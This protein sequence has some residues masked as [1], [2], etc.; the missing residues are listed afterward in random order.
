M[1]PQPL[2][3]DPEVTDA[4]AREHGLTDD[5]YARVQEVLGRVP[6]YTELGVYSVMWSEHCSY[7]NS[8]ALLKTLP[9]D[10][11]RLL[12]AAGDENAGLVDI[13]GGLACA[14][15]IESHNHPSAV[16]PYQ[17]AATGVG[18]IQRDIFTMGARP[19]ASLN[20]LRFGSLDS[21]RVRFLF[22][23]V[24]RG[25]GGYGNSF[26]VPTVGGEV[27]F[28]AS[29]EGNPLVNAMSVG[30]VKAGET[31]SATAEGVGNPVYIVG[32]ATGRDGIHGA[33]FASEEISEDSDA[34]RPNVQV[35]DPF[36]EKLLLE[37]SLEA[38][39]T[40]AVVGMQDMGAA[41]ITCSSSEMSE[42]GGVG[43]DLQLDRTPQREAG[44]TPYELLLSESQERMLV[45]V[46]R[47]REAE[48]EA[49]FDKWDLHAVQIGEVTDTE[50][51]RV[52]WHGD[53]VVDVPA[54]SLV[55]GGGAP[56]Y[57]RETQRPGYLDATRAWDA[58]DLA[59]LLPTSAETGAG[60]AGG[61]LVALMGAP[62]VAS[63]R[64]VFQQY[65]HEV[66]TNTVAGPGP[67][68]A[69]VVRLKGTTPPAA[70]GPGGAGSP[71]GAERGLAMTT[72]CNGRYVYLNPRRG[73]RIAVAEAARNVVCAGGEPLAV[74]NCLN[75]G[76]PYKPE[77]YW[78]FTEAVGGLGDACRALGTPVTGGNVSFYNE[79][80]DERGG[81]RA[82][83]PTPTIGMVGL[84]DDVAAHTTT[85][86]WA[87]PGD[88]LL[89]VSP[90]AWW[91]TGGVEASEYLAHVHGTTAGDA[92]HLDLD[93]EKAVQAAVLAAIRAGLV[94]SAH[95][96][97]D[98]GLA[99]SLAESA[100][101]S[102]LGAEVAL[103]ALDARLDAVLFGEAQSRV[104]LSVAPD[105]AQ[106]VRA[107]CAEHGAQATPIGT[108][109]DGPLQ[110]TVGA[111]PALSVPVADLA[112]PYET[113]I[114]DAM[115]A[116]EARGGPAV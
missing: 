71:G 88:R 77:V 63:K 109:T 44:M 38:I 14:F 78:Q 98:G 34:K 36:T 83:F 60:T 4:L 35:G 104:V 53:L 8:I 72:D 64:W 107:L 87:A 9:R 69:A 57:H 31:V 54:E 113:A 111:E 94:R 6:T 50:R 37:A 30:V 95:D 11:E 33:T 66:R 41:G 7:K 55:L 84:V 19:I 110:V 46:E 21:P 102:G 114:P 32:S 62:N 48:I 105:D 51:V 89:L 40:G 28:D 15:K 52:F 1:T 97:A 101:F 108:V 67:T 70:D 17:G 10:G 29:Y 26:G 20:S 73:A 103:P 115:A 100:V 81:T 22:D 45:V 91:H 106:S 65:D 5:E 82:V 24:V 99:V 49:V 42:K 92:P 13:G 25:I 43:M 75:F 3:A 116:P 85:A 74:T 86:A 23:G 96:V 56:V 16:E 12:A 39:A 112:R 47:G 27:V 2:P 80:P 79:S 93:E 76:N 59:D 58:T 68:D 61:A 18:G 90:A